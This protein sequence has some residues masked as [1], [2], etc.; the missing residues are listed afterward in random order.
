M[1][2]AG[3]SWAIQTRI[4]FSHQSLNDDWMTHSNMLHIFMM[5]H[6]PKM[7]FAALRLTHVECNADV[8]FNIKSNAQQFL[9]PCDILANVTEQQPDG[10]SIQQNSRHFSSP[11]HIRSIYF[12][13][14]IGDNAIILR[15]SFRWASVNIYELSKTS[16]QISVTYDRRLF[17]CRKSRIAMHTAYRM[18]TAGLLAGWHILLIFHAH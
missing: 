7:C 16:E 5:I 18:V 17:V 1:I 10:K 2:S 11:Q 4:S 3:F 15:N 6:S 12:V 13:V 14:A 9:I 8:E